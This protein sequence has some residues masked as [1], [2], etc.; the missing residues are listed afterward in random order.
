LNIVLS[1]EIPTHMTG[2]GACGYMH[3]RQV[4]HKTELAYIAEPL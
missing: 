1:N 4:E 3:R 2:P